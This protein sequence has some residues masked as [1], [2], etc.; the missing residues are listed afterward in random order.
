MDS[1]GWTEVTWKMRN[2][3]QGSR[4]HGCCDKRGTVL[5]SVDRHTSRMPCLSTC[6]SS[7]LSAPVHIH[8]PREHAWLSGQQ[9]SSRLLWCVEITCHPSVMSHPLQHLSTEHIHTFSQQPHLSSSRCLPRSPVRW[10]RVHIPALIR[11]GVADPLKSHL[12]KDH[13]GTMTTTGSW[14]KLLTTEPGREW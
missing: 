7:A 14:G 6:S 10:Y 2:R 4:R 9:G 8:S 3:Q 12:P 13:C 5:G 1:V 11:G